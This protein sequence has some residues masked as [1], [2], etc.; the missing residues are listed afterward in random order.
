MKKTITETVTLTKI[1]GGGQTMG[2]LP[3]G[4]KVFVWGG[5]PGETVTIQLTKLKKSYA[6]GIVSKV[7]ASS[8]ER[9]EPRDP[10]SYLSTSPWQIMNFTVEQQLKS[11]L[12]RE[13][14]ALSHIDINTPEEVVTDNKPYNYR[15]K[16]E[17]SLWWDNSSKQ[18]SLAF[19]I[20]GTHQKIPITESSIERPEIIAEAKKIINR[21]NREN[22]SARRYQSLLIRSDQAG[23]VSSALFEKHQSH[24]RMK[25]L[26]DT[27][28]GYK[29]YYSPNGFFQINLPV[30]EL[31][32]Q[33]I[34][35]SI[36]SA[37]VVD[38]YAGVGTIG[39]SVA[40]DRYLTLVETDKSAFDEMVNNIP[41]SSDNIRPVHAKSEEALEYISSDAT[42][43]LDPPRAGLHETVVKRILE[44]LPPQVI[45][46]SCNPITQARDIAPM[47][48]K[49]KIDLLQ[50]FN[51]FPR[52]P[53]IE[54][55]VVLKLI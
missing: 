3:D 15:N 26:T 46:L 8:P 18:I 4:R 11:Q 9:I 24:P 53:H 22:D 30:Y 48:G 20:R 21:L 37:K 38:M 23:N 12:V 10:D 45:Y 32:L 13:A 17:Y 33:K 52:T 5:L 34:V 49:Y 51:F 2:E 44:I 36:E 41:I 42:I 14:F 7:I 47:L 55:L 19:H 28:L 35:K 43:I 25:T 54:N 40:R 27:I 31:A 6:E 39:L 50:P 29:Y 16:M 1:I